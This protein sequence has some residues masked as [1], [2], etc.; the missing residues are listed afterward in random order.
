MLEHRARS[1]EH[2]SAG[3]FYREL[4][5]LAEEGLAKR[6]TC[7]PD[8]DQRR[9]PYYI[10]DRGSVTFDQWLAYPVAERD[11]ITCRLVFADR[12]PVG[13]RK[14]LFERWQEDLW[15]EGKQLVRARED[16]LAKRRA[17][18]GNGYDPLPALLNRQISKVFVE[19]KF[20]NEC[21]RDLNG[22]PPSATAADRQDEGGTLSVA[23]APRT[24]R[25][26][27]GKKA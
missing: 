5:K 15:I 23:A 2:L 7:P 6:G 11:E 12:I 26:G 3:N 8:V 17:R 18:T 1:G 19:V 16:A 13:L 9:V 24:A 14:E 20:L 25:S 21:L 22:D 4:A 27:G 10:S